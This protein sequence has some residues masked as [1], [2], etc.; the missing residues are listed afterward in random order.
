[1]ATDRWFSLL[2]FLTGFF[3]LVSGLSTWGE[4]PIFTQTELVKAWIPVSD[5]VLTGPVSLAT[6]YGL[7][8]GRPWGRLLGLVTSGVYLLGS[9]L[10]GTELLWKG[11]PYAWTLVIPAL[12]GVSLAVAYLAVQLRFTGSSP[13]PHKSPT[14]D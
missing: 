8:R 2:F 6:A 10:V 3:A 4:G 13:N 9:V 14:R 11:P 5:L 12:A 1:M 7:R